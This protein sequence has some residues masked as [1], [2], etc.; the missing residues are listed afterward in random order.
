MCATQIGAYKASQS[1][2]PFST[3]VTAGL[4]ALGG[5]RSIGDNLKQNT[6]LGKTF[7]PEKPKVAARAS[8]TTRSRQSSA[9]VRSGNGLRINNKDL[10]MGLQI[11]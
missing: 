3:P 11:P 8:T 2:L 6:G 9:T 5:G 1:Q 10:G 7:F 4:E